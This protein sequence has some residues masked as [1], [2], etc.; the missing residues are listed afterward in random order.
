M[1]L[2]RMKSWWSDRILAMRR[3]KKNTIIQGVCYLLAIAW[4]DYATGYEIN[5]TVLDRKSTRLNSSH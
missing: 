1:P 3:N 5:P 4:L 2:P